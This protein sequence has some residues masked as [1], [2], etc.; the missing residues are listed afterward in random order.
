MNVKNIAA[1]KYRQIDMIEDEIKK[2][3][4][5]QNSVR[6]E[7]G[8]LKKRIIDSH[9]YLIGKKAKCSIKDQNNF[10]DVECV[11][12]SIICTDDFNAKPLFKNK[13]GKKVNVDFYEWV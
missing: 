2:L 6:Q 10:Q 5:Q 11:C 13:K 12:T 9:N 3:R 8:A 4:S 7:I 1:S